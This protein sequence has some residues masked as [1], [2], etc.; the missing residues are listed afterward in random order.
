MAAPIVDAQGAW[1]IASYFNAIMHGTVILQVYLYFTRFPHDLKPIKWLVGCVLLT[2]VLQT[3]SIMAVTYRW[4]ITNFENSPGLDTIKWSFNML[5]VWDS[6]LALLAQGFFTCRVWAV[7]HKNKPLC[8]I[9]AM[10]VLTRFGLLN[11]MG[12]QTWIKQ[13]LHGLTEVLWLLTLGL[14]FSMCTDVAITT[15]LIWYL[16]K[17]RTG[18]RKTNSLINRLII[19]S[20]TTALLPCIFDVIVV[21]CIGTMPNNLIWAGIHLILTK[22]Y[23]T[24]I[25]ATLNTRQAKSSGASQEML[26]LH[27]S[28]PGTGF[29]GNTAHLTDPHIAV[30]SSH[31]MQQGVLV[32][33]EQHT[34]MDPSDT[35]VIDL[36]DPQKRTKSD[37]EYI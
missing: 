35:S 18:V 2:D 14:A 26:S 7:S 3:A 32:T 1:L 4:L 6:I 25:L 20:M 15:S 11:A 16:H 13:T 21:I 12:V 8:A 36:S 28:G 17:S 10:A 27:V 5:F 23:P 33:Q 30:S 22:T 34:H 29:S 9:L 24:A 37:L 31:P 19:Y